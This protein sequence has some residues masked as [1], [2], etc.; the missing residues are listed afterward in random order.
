MD[1]DLSFLTTSYVSVY[2]IKDIY[3]TIFFITAVAAILILNKKPLYKK[4]LYE[5]PYIK[6]GYEYKFI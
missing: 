1:L 6:S 3:I 4:P 2:K 5:K